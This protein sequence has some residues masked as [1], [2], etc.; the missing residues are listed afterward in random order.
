[1]HCDS[2]YRMGGC[3]EYSYLVE[4]NSEEYYQV[5]EDEGEIEEKLP[6]QMCDLMLTTVEPYLNT[7]TPDLYHGISNKNFIAR[8]RV[9]SRQIRS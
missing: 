6:A 1:M 2:M 3:V 9:G 5:E 7:V 8:K 4:G